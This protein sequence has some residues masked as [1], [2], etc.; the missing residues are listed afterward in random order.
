MEKDLN[1]TILETVSNAIQLALDDFDYN[2]TDNQLKDYIEADDSTADFQ[3][4][5]GQTLITQKTFIHELLK[6]LPNVD[7][8]MFAPFGFVNYKI[9]GNKKD[10]PY[11]TSLNN[12]MAERICE[13][14]QEILDTKGWTTLSGSHT[15]FELILI[16]NDIFKKYHI[17]DDKPP[18]GQDAYNAFTSKSSYWFDQFKGKYKEFNDALELLAYYHPKLKETIHFWI[19]QI[20]L[21]NDGA[22]IAVMYEVYDSDLNKS[23]HKVEIFSTSKI[24]GEKGI[25]LKEESTIK[26]KQMK[27][28]N[29]LNKINILDEKLPKLFSQTTINGHVAF[30]VSTNS[31]IDFDYRTRWHSRA[32]E[33]Y[34]L[35]RK[36]FE[37]VKT[38]DTILYIR[39]LM[40]NCLYIEDKYYN[41][42]Y[43][44]LQLNGIKPYILISSKDGKYLMAFY[45]MY[46]DYKEYKL[47]CAII[48]N[49]NYDIMPKEYLKEIEYN[50]IN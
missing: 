32:N 43:D 40:I 19:N 29:Y 24:I 3:R 42:I 13:R 25:D 49:T 31:N 9:T 7:K 18:R 15:F 47:V 38:F 11:I 10:W 1:K 20:S 45:N 46:K 17:Y 14:Y 8:K 34:E 41:G 4:H 23:K 21:S 6:R 48:D 44:E 35:F 39:H 5:L 37:Y 27:F 22:F 26:S 16:R 2:E 33:A 28:K 12:N 30:S 36:Q 50:P